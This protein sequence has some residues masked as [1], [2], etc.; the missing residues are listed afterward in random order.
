M[1]R[2]PSGQRVFSL[3]EDRLA[4]FFKLRINFSRQQL[5]KSAKSA[6]RSLLN[7]FGALSRTIAKR[8]IKQRPAKPKNRFDTVGTF[9]SGK[10]K[11]QQRII[12]G[13]HSSPGKPPRHRKGD[14]RVKDIRFAVNA[15][16]GNVVVGP[17]KYHN[18]SK[19]TDRRATN[20]LEFGGRVRVKYKKR[21]VRSKFRGKRDRVLPRKQFS[22]NMG[23]RPYMR[24]AGEQAIKIVFDRVRKDNI[25]LK[26][27]KVK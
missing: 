13:K 21:R 12:K 23:K 1:A 25:F 22:F 27:M 18:A 19:A 17:I 3:R 14:R 6:E 10:R 9:K 7:Q 11:G 15:K 5:R 26:G 2:C 20:S 8:S 16:A 4:T 24:P